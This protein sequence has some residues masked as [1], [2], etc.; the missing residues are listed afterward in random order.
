[1]KNSLAKLKL[2]ASNLHQFRERDPEGQ[3]VEMEP[4]SQPTQQPPKVKKLDKL[5]LE[6]QKFCFPIY[7]C[8]CLISINVGLQ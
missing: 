1:M 5:I 8:K 7:V 6:E 2:M 4:P 3:I